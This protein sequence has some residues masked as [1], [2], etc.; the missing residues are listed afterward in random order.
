MWLYFYNPH[1]YKWGS[2]VRLSNLPKDTQLARDGI[3]VWSWTR[4]SD[5]EPLLFPLSV[6]AA[7]AICFS[8]H[9]CTHQRLC[10]CPLG[11][12][13]V[14]WSQKDR[15]HDL[16]IALLS[17]TVQKCV[18]PSMAPAGGASQLDLASESLRC[19]LLSGCRS[20]S[21]LLWC[22]PQFHAKWFNSSHPQHSGESSC[23][24]TKMRPEVAQSM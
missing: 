17:T 22:I 20:G 19:L 18:Q 4:L 23:W 10:L 21:D 11:E 12:R 13:T 8:E 14:F 3:K 7:W 9:V 6:F 15:W 5:S 16:S 24:L 2:S 1:F